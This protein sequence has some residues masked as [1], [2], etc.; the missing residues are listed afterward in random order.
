MN[1]NKKTKVISYKTIESKYRSGSAQPRRKVNVEVKHRNN[2]NILHVERNHSFE[3]RNV[4]NDNAAN[5]DK[6]SSNKKKLDSNK[7]EKNKTQIKRIQE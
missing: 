1:R 6:L 5:N 4:D 2:K 7:K 3:D